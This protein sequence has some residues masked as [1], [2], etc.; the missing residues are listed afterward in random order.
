MS[1]FFVVIALMVGIAATSLAGPPSSSR[2]SSSG[3]SRSFSSGSRTN[4]A[5][6]RP[7][8]PVSRPSTPSRSFSSGSSKSTPTPHVSAPAAS[9]SVSSKP[10]A[11]KMQTPI[12]KAAQ[13]SES[14]QA[15]KAA[16][17][18]KTTPTPVA[19]KTTRSIPPVSPKKV[20]T[21][22]NVTHERYV[23]YDNR[24]SGF[25]GSRYQ[26]TYYHDS[27]SPFLM[28]YLTS[29]AL[30]SQQRAMWVYNHQSDMDSAR[31][32]QLLASDANLRAEIER[33]KASNAP[34]DASY[35]PPGMADNPDLMYDKSFVDAHRPKDSGISVWWMLLG[36]TAIGGVVYL[37]FFRK[38]L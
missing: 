19:T 6:S 13:T 17:A 31:Y 1:R 4:S 10:V 23:T 32:Q 24:A 20:E 33:L 34:V 37:V 15:Y 22:R 14:R 8:A 5:S 2:S 29:S 26:P 25:Y 11:S 9:K 36:I 3:G 16:T 18:P 30:N 38:W 7:I 12:T 21:V 28:G 27:F 35:V